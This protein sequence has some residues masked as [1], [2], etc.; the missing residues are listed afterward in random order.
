MTLLKNY[1]LLMEGHL[2]FS[3][4]IRVSDDCRSYGTQE[5]N[6]DMLIPAT[7]RQGAE[8]VCEP[9]REWCK[10]RHKMQRIKLQYVGMD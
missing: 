2:V 3:S 10:T 9:N 1:F 4:S 6:D 7:D 8:S 5:H